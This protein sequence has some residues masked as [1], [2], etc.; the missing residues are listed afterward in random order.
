MTV[1]EFLKDNPHPSEHD[2]RLGIPGHLGICTGYT[3][4]VRAIQVAAARV[5]LP[6]AP[7]QAPD[8]FYEDGAISPNCVNR[9]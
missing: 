7:R 1:L 9:T 3:N 5:A 8:F 2:M 6:S 4:I